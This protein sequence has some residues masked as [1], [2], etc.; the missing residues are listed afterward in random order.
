[1]NS[2]KSE[3]V[4]KRTNKLHLF[5]DFVKLPLGAKKKKKTN[6]KQTNK[7]TGQDDSNGFIVLVFV[8]P[9][10]TELAGTFTFSHSDRPQDLMPI[11]IQKCLSFSGTR[12]CG[13][14]GETA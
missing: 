4:R 10:V 13:N 7:K 5:A 12:P 11:F 2:C 9:P 8:F 6:K 1:M 3:F 14:T